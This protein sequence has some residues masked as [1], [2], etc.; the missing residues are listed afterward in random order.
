[1]DKNLEEMKC[2]ECARCHYHKK[3]GRHYCHW[4]GFWVDPNEESC[5]DFILN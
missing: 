3:T 2:N 5:Q 4:E 1:M